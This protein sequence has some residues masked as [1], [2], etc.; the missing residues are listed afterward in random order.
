[1]ISRTSVMQYRT[2]TVRNLREIGKQLGVAHLLEG[3]V[4]RAAGKVRVNAQLIDARTDAHLW[5]QTYDRDLADVFAIQ[6]DIAK[7]IAARLQA[8]LAPKEK[9]RLASKPTE[10]PEAYLLYL[11][12]NELVH[13]AASK[14]DAFNADKI[15]RQAIA[16]D[17]NFALAYAKAS[18]LNSLIYSMGRDPA[19]IV[20]AR[21]LADEALR[22]APNLGEAHL[23]S[24]L[25]FYRVDRDY[26]AALKELAIAGAASPNDPEILDSTG[27]IYRRQG[28]WR[29]ALALFA[30][31]RELDPRRAH[32]QGLPETLRIFRQWSAASDA[33]QQALQLE[34]QLT[35]GWIGLAHVQ[36]AQSGAPSAAST[37]L[38]HLPDA[39]KNKP[40]ATAAQWDYAMLARDFAAAA[41]LIPDRKSYEFPVLE[42]ASY[43]EACIAFAQG[44]L[45]RAR[46]LLEEIRP[47]HEA[48]VRDH[49]DDPIFHSALAK[50]YALLGRK[51]DAIR[52][53][54][55]AVELC[56]ESKDAISGPD[57]AADLA[58]AYAQGSDVEQAVT[59]LSRLLTTPGAERITLA[60]LRLSWEWDPLRQDPRF[61]A[62]IEGPEP[63]TVYH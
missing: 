27:F 17:P 57:Y 41:K 33:Y 34:P 2:G 42:P 63:V 36:F 22:L 43:F 23:A 38:D 58:F 59:L 5:A 30:R 47:L 32:P 44:D 7:S 54:R 48:G 12:A 50:V 21:F 24:G 9:V 25:C 37:T 60:H 28:R 62:L 11:Q 31:A 49:P 10:N 19:R 3:S 35:D 55:R 45:A 14:L 1:V 20:S 40:L 52:E 51:E 61:K 29:E 26:D 46:G 4:Q 56:P 13:V 53:A 16:L 18:I 6:S 8:K 39:M 15:Y